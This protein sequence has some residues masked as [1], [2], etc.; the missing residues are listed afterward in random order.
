M[1]ANLSIQREFAQRECEQPLGYTKNMR[2]D[3]KN[4][5]GEWAPLPDSHLGQKVL[6]RRAANKLAVL[7]VEALDEADPLAPQ[8]NVLQD[9]P[10]ELVPDGRKGGLTVKQ[11]HARLLILGVQLRS[12]VQNDDVV[13]H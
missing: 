4:R 3:C 12:I 2:T 10:H 8:P 13:T 5:R 6:L 1:Q 7:K 9:V 11:Y